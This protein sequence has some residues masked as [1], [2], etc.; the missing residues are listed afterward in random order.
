MPHPPEHDSPEPYQPPVA[1]L[2]AAYTDALLAGDEAA[3]EVVIREAMDAGLGTAEIDEQLIAPALWLVGELW[4]R[5]EL[6][7]A[8]EHLATEITVRVLALQR[9]AQRVARARSS[10][11]VILATLPGEQHVV[12]LRMVGNLLRD[13][14]YHVL[15]LGAEVPARSLGETAERHGAD[16]ICVSSTMPSRSRDTLRML[17]EVR[18]ARPSARFVIGGRGL[19]GD[20]RLRHE[21]HTCQRVSEAVEAVDA[22]LKRARLN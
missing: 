4:Q 20:E 10:H 3:A 12:A 1:Q 5:G 6:S 19:C 13:A 14:G 16:V 21:V 15:M 18:A 17:D 2:A 22:V 9:E 11:A 8:D 7:V